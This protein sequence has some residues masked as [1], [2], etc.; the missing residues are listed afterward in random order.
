MHNTKDRARKADHGRQMR[1]GVIAIS[2]NSF[3]AIVGSTDSMALANNDASMSS[4]IEWE[5]KYG[6]RCESMR[7]MKI[8][9]ASSSGD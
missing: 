5:E 4:W 6:R 9:N 8:Q 2:T 3:F 7:E 1:M